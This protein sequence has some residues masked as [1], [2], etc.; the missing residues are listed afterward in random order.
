MR[1]QLHRNEL[2]SIFGAYV[3]NYLHQMWRTRANAWQNHPTATRPGLFQGVGMYGADDDAAYIEALGVAMARAAGNYRRKTRWERLSE[4][5]LRARFGKWL[6]AKLAG[7]TS[8][9][10]SRQNRQSD[11]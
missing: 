6:S 2:C 3:K 1:I 5:F 10:P 11:V 4:A 9:H 7:K 8:R